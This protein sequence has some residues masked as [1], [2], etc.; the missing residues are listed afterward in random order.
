MNF[1]TPTT[2]V[3]ENNLVENLT[4][5]PNPSSDIV[6]ILFSCID[7]QSVNIKVINVLGEK[8]FSESLSQFVGEY[9]KQIDLKNYPKAV[10]FLEIETEKGVM[11]KKLILQ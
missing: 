7:K 8:I 4:I 2:A 11:N 3:N 5:Y 6:N 1:G 10:Y 9:K